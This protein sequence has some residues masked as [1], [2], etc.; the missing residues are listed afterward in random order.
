M[1][2]L[3]WQ[4]VT[5]TPGF[6]FPLLT[7]ANIDIVNLSIFSIANIVIVNIINHSIVFY[8]Q[9]CHCHH[10]QPFHC[11]PFLFQNQDSIIDCEQFD[12]KREDLQ[13][14]PNS[15]SIHIIK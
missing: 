11:I 3:R 13:Q 4:G 14:K 1:P 15:I 2:E 7:I 6:T 9:N 12:K 10:C 8:C 5:I